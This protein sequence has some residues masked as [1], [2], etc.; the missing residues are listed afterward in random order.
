MDGSRWE[1]KPGLSHQRQASLPFLPISEI[2]YL[3]FNLLRPKDCCCFGSTVRKSCGHIFCG[4]AVKCYLGPGEASFCGPTVF[5]SYSCPH[6]SVG[7]H[8]QVEMKDP[9]VSVWVSLH[10]LT[11]SAAFNDSGGN[12]PFREPK[13]QNRHF[14]LCNIAKFRNILSLGKNC[15]SFVFRTR[16]CWTWCLIK[17]RS[18]E[19]PN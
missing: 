2:I 5:S 12:S 16:S 19:E 13:T 17:V 11:V 6:A 9:V 18:L 8:F 14:H 7:R 15:N 10:K 1:L 3:S 4:I